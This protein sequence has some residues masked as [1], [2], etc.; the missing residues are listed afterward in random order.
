MATF[1]GIKVVITKPATQDLNSIARFIARDN[2]VRARSYIERLRVKAK[3]IA[4][5]PHGYEVIN[6]A[7]GRTVR[8]RP[9][10]DYVIFY[11]IDEDRIVIIRILHSARDFSEL[12]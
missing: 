2:P 9:V 12:I 8:R 10:D 5:A 11:E 3:S 1:E 7:F 4:D 6:S